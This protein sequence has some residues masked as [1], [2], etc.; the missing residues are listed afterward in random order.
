MLHT[1]DLF[2]VELNE[3]KTKGYGCLLIMLGKE[4]SLHLGAILNKN[5]VLV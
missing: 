4:N 1:L 3:A 5:Y 2:P